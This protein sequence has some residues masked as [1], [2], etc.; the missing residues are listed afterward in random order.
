M[1]IITEVSRVVGA[2]VAV[3]LEGRA[4]GSNRGTQHL[5]LLIINLGVV[6]SSPTGLTNYRRRR[7]TAGPITIAMNLTS[8]APYTWLLST[9]GLAVGATCVPAPDRVRRLASFCDKHFRMSLLGDL[10]LHRPRTTRPLRVVA[11]RPWSLV[12]YATGCF[13]DCDF[14]EGPS[15][16]V[17]RRSSQA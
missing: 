13:D 8:E 5:D 14:V 7:S 3:G 12:A 4:A 6:G 17:K 10:Q 16:S 15:G 11:N 9:C 1:G 2:L